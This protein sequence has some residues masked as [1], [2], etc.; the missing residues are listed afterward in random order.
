MLSKILGMYRLR[1]LGLQYLGGYES[2]M[3]SVRTVAGLREHGVFEFA[4]RLSG[5]FI[6][7]LSAG[8]ADLRVPLQQ[9]E[10]LY[11]LAHCRALSG[12]LT[13]LT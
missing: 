13:S 1:P 11:S 9:R 3:R 12:V 2:G 4:L 6:E 5:Q 7:L 8:S 10:M